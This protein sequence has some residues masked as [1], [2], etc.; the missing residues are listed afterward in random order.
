MDHRRS[1]NEAIIQPK[2][3]RPARIPL[4]G[5]RGNG[6]M[7][8]LKTNAPHLIEQQMTFE[9]FSSSNV[10]GDIKKDSDSLEL[11]YGRSDELYNENL[12]PTNGWD[13]NHDWTIL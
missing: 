10:R 4:G 2:Q 7:K 8:T 13:G 9:G 11:D 3:L 5:K 12:Q 1:R 6:S